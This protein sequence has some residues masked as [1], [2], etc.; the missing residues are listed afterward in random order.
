MVCPAAIVK[1]SPL[2]GTV[3]PQLVHIDESF[4]LPLA[5]DTQAFVKPVVESKNKQ[6]RVLIAA[7]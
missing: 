5:E 2:P 4:Q 7:S 3:P 1:I 6:I